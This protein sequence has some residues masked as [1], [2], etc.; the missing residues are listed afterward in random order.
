MQAIA[1]AA[2]LRVTKEELEPEGIDL[3]IIQ[4]RK[5]LQPRTQRIEVQVKAR[6]GVRVVDEN[7]RVDLRAKQFHALNGVF[8]VDYDVRRY[9]VLVTVPDHFSEYYRCGDEDHLRFHNRA[10]WAD[11]MGMPDLPSSQASTTV[12]VPKCNLLTSEAL[13]ELVCG[14]HEEAVRWM[15]A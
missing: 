15:S 6:T 1:A 8:Q 9:L 12:S 2:G 11:L 13:V 3:Q 7:F 4:D 14:D 10:Y 5:G